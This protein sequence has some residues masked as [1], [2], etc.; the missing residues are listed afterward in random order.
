MTSDAL[1]LDLGNSRL[2]WALLR[3]GALEA[4]AAIP[5]GDEGLGDL[6]PLFAAAAGLRR[7]FLSSTAGSLSAPLRLAIREQ[8]GIDLLQFRSPKQALG[9]R[10]AYDAPETLGTDRFLAMAGARARCPGQPLLIADAGT[11]MTID[12][13]D[14]D[15]QHIGGLIVPGPV[16]M[17]EALHRGTAGVRTGA[18]ARLHEW[19][20]NTDDAVWSGACLAGVA[21]IERAVH[22]A[23]IG[24]GA[25]V[26]LLCSGGSMPAMLDEIRVAHRWAPN[27]VLEGLAVWAATTPG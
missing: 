8:L 6:G 21:L 12:L 14:E 7:A 26:A 1:L 24:I 19:A 4:G 20:R 10:S 2:K 18:Q 17:R 13:V 23:Q 11:A 25:E 15:G 16:L 9:I 22:H 27:L 5:H 3:E